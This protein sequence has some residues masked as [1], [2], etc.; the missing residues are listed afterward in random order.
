MAPY[1]S[2]HLVIVGSPP[3][4]SADGLETVRRIRGFDRAIP[5]IFLVGSSEERA[6]RALVDSVDRYFEGWHPSR[7]WDRPSERDDL[8]GGE[9]LI[10]DSAVIRAIRRQRRGPLVSINCPAIPD[11]PGKRASTRSVQKRRSPLPGP[12][13]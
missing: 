10:G 4:R 5:M 3:D 2:P 12:R 11:G 9:R 1:E 13:S 6:I 8:I 7:S